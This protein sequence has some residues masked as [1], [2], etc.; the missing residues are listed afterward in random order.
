M[1]CTLQGC[2]VH[3]QGRTKIALSLSL[4]G[5][6]QVTTSNMGPE[7]CVTSVAHHMNQYDPV[8]APQELGLQVEFSH[9]AHQYL[10]T[11]EQSLHIKLFP[12]SSGKSWISSW[13][14]PSILD[15]RG[16]KSSRDPTKI[17]QTSIHN[18]SGGFCLIRS[19]PMMILSVLCLL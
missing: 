15:T 17:T 10:P 4:G 11:S 14:I 7:V 2:C 9:L 13:I 1:L 18:I 8:K 19:M 16:S 12:Q 3:D 6:Y 5:L